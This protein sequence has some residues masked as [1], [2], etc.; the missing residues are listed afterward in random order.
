MSRTNEG[1][2]IAAAFKA[3]VPLNRKRTSTDGDAVYLFGNKIAWH[4]DYGRIY[5]TLCGWPGPIARDRLNAIA[6]SWSLCN[7]VNYYNG[8]PVGLNE[9]VCVGVGELADMA[10]A[11]DP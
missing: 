1:R 3:R 10:L 8:R 6:G 11:L 4:G 2:E 9:I 7:Y 5:M